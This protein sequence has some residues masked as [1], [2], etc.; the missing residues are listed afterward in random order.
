MESIKDFSTINYAVVVGYIVLIA[1][2]GS[3]FYRRRSTPK[4]YFLGGRGMSWLPV[5][6][7]IVAADLSAISVMGG[8]AWTYRH[9]LEL[10]VV[11]FAYPLV[12][13]LVIL[14]FV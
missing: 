4:E 12:A 11:S 9:N 2:L 10:L 1:L 8:P 6:I 5:G 7:S 13:P 14:V 3:S